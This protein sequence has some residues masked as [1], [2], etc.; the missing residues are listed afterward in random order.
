[1]GAIWA[2]HALL[3]LIKG[4]LDSSGI[5]QIWIKGHLGS[6]GLI[7]GHLSSFLIAKIFIGAATNYGRVTLYNK[8]YVYGK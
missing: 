8:V 1:M 2:L 4:H 3:S 6:A 7:R 5:M